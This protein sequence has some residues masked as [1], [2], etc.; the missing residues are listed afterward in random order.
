MGRLLRQAAAERTHGQW[1]LLA[2]AAGVDTSVARTAEALAR[3]SIDRAERDRLAS[4]SS[5]A[6]RVEALAAHD[7]GLLAAVAADWISPREIGGS[8]WWTSVW[9]SA[10]RHLDGIRALDPER[11][12]VPELLPEL[13]RIHPP[14]GTPVS[15]RRLADRIQNDPF[16]YQ[17]VRRHAADPLL[18]P[19]ITDDEV[20]AAPFV[21]LRLLRGRAHLLDDAARRRVATL[22]AGALDKHPLQGTLA[23]ELCLELG[24]DV[25]ESVE[26]RL[27]DRLPSLV[28]FDVAPLCYVL[29]G[30]WRLP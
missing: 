24:I 8:D 10:L 21:M 29:L 22:A 20:A 27:A 9:T 3:T 28:P 7:P 19:K 14:A 15:W 5:L 16:A 6:D 2:T 13:E 1:E 4:P 17:T 18:E 12:R 11:A 30:A 25:A 23:V 26:R